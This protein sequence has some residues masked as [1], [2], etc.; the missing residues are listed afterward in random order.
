MATK[1]PKPP[2][3]GTNWSS[4]EVAAVVAD[5]FTMLAD[6]LARRPYNKRDHNRALQA[7][8][9]R[10]PGSIEFKHQNISAIL[11]ELGL[12]WL[13]GY[14]PRFNYQEALVAE[15]EGH[16]S[17]VA[18]LDAAPTAPPQVADDVSTTF[19][20]PPSPRDAPR[21]AVM[22][23][24]VRKFDPA[25][26]DE[27]NRALGTAGEEFVIE[28]ERRGIHAAGRPDLM[29]RVV[30]VS[31]EQGDGVGYDIQ[32][33]NPKSGEKLLIEVKT[34]RGGMTTPFY[35]TRNEEAVSRARPD[36]W[37]LY[38]VFNFAAAPRIFLLPPPLDR[39]ANLAPATWVASFR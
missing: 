25:G 37:R 34:T 31:R 23:R 35:V 22:E 6:Q 28:V 7:F 2:Q 15:V 11:V 39:T 19:V 36:E 18:G 29:D 12:P 32:S 17:G 3:S 13:L 4:S 26:R 38:R 9:G 5:Y 10:S 21:N 1:L 30:W 8:T 27:R 20:L 16:L 14:K 24:L 33:I